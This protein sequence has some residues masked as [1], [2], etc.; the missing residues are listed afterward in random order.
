MLEQYLI[1]YKLKLTFYYLISLFIIPRC[2]VKLRSIVYIVN[3]MKKNLYKLI[4]LLQI[5][6]H[7][8]PVG[9]Q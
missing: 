9:L 2:G 3:K 6:T 8:K 5:F 4:V 1:F 7:C